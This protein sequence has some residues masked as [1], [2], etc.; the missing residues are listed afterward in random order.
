MSKLD[1]DLVTINITDEEFVCKVMAELT[2]VEVIAD[3][4][5]HDPTFVLG[6]TIVGMEIWKKLQE[7]AR[8]QVVANTLKNMNKED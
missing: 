2:D 6:M 1:K 5:Q 3:I 7:L 4:L 8:M